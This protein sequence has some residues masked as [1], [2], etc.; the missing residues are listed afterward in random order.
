VVSGWVIRANEP[1][2][3]LPLQ[4]SYLVAV[5]TSSHLVVISPSVS[6]VALKLAGL[7]GCLTS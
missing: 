6:A 2:M 7:A 5:A 4:T 3:V 1:L